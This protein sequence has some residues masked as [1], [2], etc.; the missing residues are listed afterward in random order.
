MF[1]QNNS[2]VHRLLLVLFSKYML[3]FYRD[4]REQEARELEKQKERER[5]REKVEREKQER[6][7][8][9]RIE[10]EKLEKQ[11]AAEQAVH[12]H[13]EESLRLAHQKFSQVFLCDLL[14][15]V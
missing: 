1:G 7:R 15:D 3:M 8:Q 10:R 6:E 11:R 12:K 9:E 13:F 4:R 5:E 2:K 14:Y